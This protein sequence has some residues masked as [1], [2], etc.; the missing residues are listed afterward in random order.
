MYPN[1]Q[2]MLGILILLLLGIRVATK[3]R[4]TG[5]I[6]DKPK[7]NFLVQLVNLFNLC[8]L[9]IVNPLVAILLV[10]QKMRAIDPTRL[11]IESPWLVN[12]LAIAG[13][14]LYIT[15]FFLMAWALINLR[16]NYQLGGSL[17]RA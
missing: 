11:T 15:G 13:L 2:R 17:P 5:S 9:L 16:N 4:S 6:L 1:N 12:T 7:G 8:F 10:T 3:Q 14:V